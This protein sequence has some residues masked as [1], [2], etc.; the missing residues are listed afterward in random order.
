[1]PFS[2]RY[3][4]GPKL[5]ETLAF[6][7]PAVTLGRARESDVVVPSDDVRASAHHAEISNENDRYLLRDVGSRNG[8]LVNGEL[9]THFR[10]NDGDVIELG[11]GGPRFRF[12]RV[13]RDDVRM[14]PGIDPPWIEPPAQLGDSL[15]H[16]A[17][18][19][20]ASESPGNTTIQ[21]LIGEL[22]RRSNRRT[23]LL[24]S[25]LV[26]IFVVL[27]ASAL[28]YVSRHSPP[29]FVRVARENQAAVV[30]IRCEYDVKD[31]RGMTVGQIARDG[32]GF[33]IGSEG[34]IVTNRHLVRVWEYD[35]E[36]K[37][38]HL[39]GDLKSILVVFADH[40]F[41]EA[42]RAEVVHMSQSPDIDVAALRVNP[43]GEIPVVRH[44]NPS[45]QSVQQGDPI[46]V[47]GYPLG[48]ELLALTRDSR[49]RTTLSQGVVSRLTPD[50]IQVD[51]TA[52]V[53]NSGGPVFNSKG[54]VIGI[55]TAGVGGGSTKEIAFVTP[56]KRAMDLLGLK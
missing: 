32:T 46:A 14:A 1:M 27:T 3:L 56:I 10:L 22:G 55:L 2:L 17:P 6:G 43:S 52:S 12:E 23:V 53:G 33:V 49:A 28:L 19:P 16:P 29:D 45:L 31:E 25:V 30:L 48:T 18:Q 37:D 11:S 24:S 5:G 41:A 38:R 54:E 51:A 50:Y 9:G 13:E 15:A 34:T 42:Q 36:L 39:T 47:I 40:S 44:I 21:R 35:R 4:N 20:A 26:L 7:Q 8:T